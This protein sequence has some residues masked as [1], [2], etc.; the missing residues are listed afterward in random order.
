MLKKLYITLLAAAIFCCAQTAWADQITM[1]AGTYYFDFIEIDGTVTQFQVFNNATSQGKQVN[2]DGTVNESTNFQAS[3][4]EFDSSE[5]L[6]TGITQDSWTIYRKSGMTYLVLTLKHGIYIPQQNC[7][8]YQTDNNS[9]HGWW[10]YP[11]SVTELGTRQYYCKL[12]S[13]GPV[14]QTSGVLPS[15]TPRVYFSAGD[16]GSVGTHT[17][18]GANISTGA[19]VEEG[20]AVNLV[21]TPETGYAFFG[22]RDANGSIVSTAANYVFSMPS[23][24]ISLTAVFHTESTDPVVDGCDGCFLIR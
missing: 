22:W 7:M 16:H 10:Q 3:D 23:T 4:V 18:G 5:P 12:T 13:T 9:W 24:N 15:T 19:A 8:Q 2:Q 1:P 20:T 21:A 6:N 14:W 17:A 11:T